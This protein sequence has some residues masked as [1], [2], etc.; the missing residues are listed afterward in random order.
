MRQFP[1][2]DDRLAACGYGVP[3][4]QLAIA[5]A[6]DCATTIVEDEMPN[7]VEVFTPKKVPPKRPTTSTYEEKLVRVAK[8][9]ELPLPVDL[10]LH[11][12][13]VSAELRVTLSYFAEPNTFRR[14]VSRGLDLRWDMQG[15]QEDEAAFKARIN[16]LAREE[17]PSEWEGSYDWI[18][19]PSRRQRGTVQSDRWVGPAPMLAGS[20]LLAVYP[21]GGWWDQRK[22]LRLEAMPFSLIVTVRAS[23]LPIYQVLVDSL[24]TSVTVDGV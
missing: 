4:L 15:P 21:V 12:H 16:K 23:S 17:G 9:F 18:I 11:A 10:L 14:K 8:F 7:R 20:K 22:G 1:G 3:D 13:D 24:S 2:L 6:A 19:G 5:C